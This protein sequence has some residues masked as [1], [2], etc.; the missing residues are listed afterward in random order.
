MITF[1]LPLI[2][3][4]AGGLASLQATSGTLPEVGYVDL[5]GKLS[6]VDHVQ[7]DGE[8]LSLKSY[9]DLV[10]AQSAK[11]EG[12]IDAYLVVPTGYLHGEAVRYYGE[13]DPTGKVRTALEAF[14]RRSLL[15]DLPGRT[16]DRLDEPLGNLTFLA[17]DSNTSV[18]DG[19]A[20]AVRVLFPFALA[21]LFGFLVMTNVSQMGAAMVREKDQRAMEIVLTSLP[22]WQLVAGKVLGTTLLS[23]TQIAIWGIGFVLALA[24]AISRFAPSE[25]IEVPVEIL[26]WSLALFLPSYFLY[27]TLAAGVGIVAG[28]ARQA[29]QASSAFGVF[30]MAPFFVL[31]T[32]MDDPNGSVAVLLSYFPLTAPMISV[33]RMTGT[34]IPTWQ[35]LLATSISVFALLGSLW[36]VARVYRASMLLYGQPLRPK[37]I[38]RALRGPAQSAIGGEQ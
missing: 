37:A 29:Q 13:S 14:M 4:V 7:L 6:P 33:L 20:L 21:S 3:V 22:P 35:L 8:A 19:F 10:A 28:N 5:S 15:P 18:K 36:L 1:G 34:T 24:L 9:P 31:K 25:T 26:G 23:L 30:G 38:L 32:I 11:S 17:T 27:M 16:H 2:M 12:E